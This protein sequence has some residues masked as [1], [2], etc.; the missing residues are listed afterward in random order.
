MH[1]LL[2]ALL[3]KGVT[4]VHY[5]AHKENVVNIAIDGIRSRLCLKR[6]KF[7]PIEIA[8]SS[9]LE[10][11]MRRTVDGMN[12]VCEFVPFYFSWFTAMQ[13]E[14]ESRSIEGSNTLIFLDVSV[15]SIAD[16]ARH[17]W[18][19]SMNASSQFATYINDPKDLRYSNITHAQVVKLNTKRT[20]RVMVRGCELLIPTHV[21]SNC[22][23]R[24]VCKSEDVK[25]WL[26]EKLAGIPHP[27]ISQNS[28]RFFFDQF[29]LQR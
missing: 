20:S 10:K 23:T 18:V 12:R 3:Q 27:P 5:M 21:P 17:A 4:E 6:S 8:N 15:A 14:V 7:T 22:I 28:E 16:I 26:L 9:V 29:G 2:K 19:S 13:K 24:M 11:R 1:P 25:S